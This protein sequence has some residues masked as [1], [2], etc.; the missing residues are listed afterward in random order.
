M[1]QNQS[2]VAVVQE[3][4]METAIGTVLNQAAGMPAIP[5]PAG[6]RIKDIMDEEPLSPRQV[7]VWEHLVTLV[8][9]GTGVRLLREGM[10]LNQT[11][12]ANLWGGTQSAISIMESRNSRLQKRSRERLQMVVRNLISLR[13]A[14]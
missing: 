12:F 13:R 5:A 7:K 8:E 3:Q 6:L 10:G 4:K 11:E 9:N 14:R 2:I 1:T